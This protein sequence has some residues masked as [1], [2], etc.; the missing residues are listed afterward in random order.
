[1]KDSPL[2]RR[3]ILGTISSIYD[4]LGLAGPFILKGRK[5]LQQ[6]TMEN[7]SWDED[8]SPEMRSAWEK[9]RVELHTLQDLQTKR[10]YKPSSFKV[11]SSSL[12]NFSDASDYGYGQA[13][14]LRQ[15]SEE[16]GICVSL[17][18]GKSRVVPSK[19]TTVPRMELV[20]ALVSSKVAAM[21]QEELDIGNLSRSYW[22]D[23]RVVLGYICNDVRR[24]RTFVA[25][26]VKKIRKL[27][28]KGQ[29][30][31]I[32]TDSNLLMMHHVGYR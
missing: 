14:Y 26:R 8:I 15:V 19:P 24:F 2:T 1:M 21:L 16:G 22:V 32:S 10:C 11:V 31:Y 5:I 17:V 29:W 25:N 20:A 27:T 9:W 30:S 28:E 23:S 12:H 7:S 3:G 18:M 6:I 13:S 4:P